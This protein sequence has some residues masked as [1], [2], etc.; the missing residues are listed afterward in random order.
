[1]APGAWFPGRVDE[2]VQ[3]V[4][5]PVLAA[6]DCVVWAPLAGRL[7]MLSLLV[8]IAAPFPSPCVAPISTMSVSGEYQPVLI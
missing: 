5:G 6:G 7:L 1:M 8:A 3:R 2:P 4:A